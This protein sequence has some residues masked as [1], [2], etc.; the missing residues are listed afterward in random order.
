MSLLES[1]WLGDDATGGV[2]AVSCGLGDESEGDAD[3]VEFV[4]A[5]GDT[6]NAV[7]TVTIAFAA[8]AA[9]L[10]LTVPGRVGVGVDVVGAPP[11]GGL[12]T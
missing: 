9:A 11:S 8:A 3:A 10:S 4:I 2:G 7:G 12:R 6:W 5:H 1:F